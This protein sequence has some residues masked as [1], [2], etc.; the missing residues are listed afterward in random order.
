MAEEEVIEGG[1]DTVVVR[2]R[3]FPVRAILL[4]AARLV[5]VLLALVAL[6]VLY[7]NTGSGRQFIVGQ[8]AKVAPASGLRVSVGRIE[9][10]VL[11]N[12]TLYDVKFRDAQNKLFLTVPAVELNWRPYKFPFTGLDVR[13]LVLHDGT[14]YAKPKLNPGNPNAPTLPNFDIRVDRFVI[15]NMTV[16][17]GLLGEERHVDF[18]AHAHVHRGL[19][20]LDANGQ[21]GGGDRFT[22]LVDAEP[23]GNIFNLDLDYRA[24]K[25]GLLA[26]LAGSK[27]DLRARLLGKGTWT[28][29]D[30]AFVAR[31]DGNQLAALKLYN[32][33]GIYRISGLVWHRDYLTGL[34]ARALG[35]STAVALFGTL[36]NSVLSGSA[37]LRG[38]GINVDGNG[39]VDLGHNAFKTAA[40]K[41][42]LVDKQLFGPGLTMRDVVIRTTLDGPW[43]GFTA[44]FELKV[45]QADFGGTVFTGIG[46]RGRLAYDGTRW[47]L[48][49]D[50]SVE[51]IVTGNA[52]IDPRLT[53]G[54]LTGTVYLTNN[55][56]RSDDL[57]LRF[58]GL[59]ANLTLRGDIARGGY[60]IAGAVEGRDLIVQNLG[61]VDFGAKMRFRI[62]NGVP[63]RVAANFSGRMPKISNATLA[64]FSG[65][66]LR[67]TGGVVFGAAQPIVFQKLAVRANKLSLLLNGGIENGTTTL[68]GSGRSADYG[69][70]TVKATL[71]RNGPHADLVFANPLPSAGL[72]EVHI[73]LSPTKE[74]FKIDTSG[75]S[76]L[77]PFKGLL[78][79]TSPPGGAT[80]IRIEHLD[81]WHTAVSGDLTLGRGAASGT[82][83]LAGGGLNGT[84]ALAPRGNA[85]GFTV[86][87]TANDATFGGATPLAVR[88]ATIAVSGFVGGGNSSI[89]G[90]VQAA[91][92]SYG[93]LFVG[94]LAA[95]ANVVNGRGTFDGSIAGRRGAR[96]DLQFTGNVAPNQI[97]VAARGS[98]GGQPI[99]MPRRAVLLKQR[100]GSWQLQRTQVSFGGGI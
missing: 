90:N 6:A 66:N 31:E 71:A 55:D 27:Q 39:G 94:R 29:W 50:A 63:W 57:Q 14:L 8:I 16:S 18:Q 41:I 75:Q 61:T 24:P 42:D 81:V 1:G 20:K 100:D 3:R 36:R 65:G 53:H 37:A 28:K 92:I 86:N 23:D 26:T 19:V 82:L 9:G 54:T 99:T 2:R 33:S 25:G 35:D 85:Q 88:Q 78:F 12:A 48:P 79:L 13:A 32:R 74:G 56:L 21:F 69:A 51:R 80:H 96:F 34:P 60:G 93:S 68:V 44:P 10:S 17:K 84:I 70:F 11:W 89:Q 59:W 95:R 72:R 43:R 47:T 98:Y 30:G 62:G 91:G 64:N 45:G 52:I 73:A 5:V 87:L 58:A 67:F 7:L 46:E 4:W 97:A 38:A 15:D 76:T 22:A 49:L 83:R 40:L 77:G